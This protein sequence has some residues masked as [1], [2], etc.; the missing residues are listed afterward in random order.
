MGNT[1]RPSWDDTFLDICGVLAQRSKDESTKL[2]AVIVGPANEIR[3][4]GYNCF[5][6][7]LNDDKPERQLRPAKY[8]YFEHAERNSLYNAARTGTSLVGC[9]CY[10]AF[11]PCADCARG[12][13]QAGIT[14]IVCRTDIVPERFRDNCTASSEMLR[15]AEVKVR[16][17]NSI[18]DLELKIGEDWGI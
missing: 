8:F 17:A 15:E 10:V 4:M 11:H 3:A 13:I 7:G 16:L 5:P 9:R 1:N 2:G 14:E 12:L 6:R 18:E